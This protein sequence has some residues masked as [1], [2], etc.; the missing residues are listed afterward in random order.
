MLV[1]YTGVL[2]A[3]ISIFKYSKYTREAR[4]VKCFPL[5]LPKAKNLFNSAHIRK[6]CLQTLW[7]DFLGFDF[8]GF[9]LR[10]TCFYCLFGYWFDF[11]ML[12]RKKNS[13]ILLSLIA[14]AF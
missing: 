7:I 5:L 12:F 1:K 3:T 4:G 11:K 2:R 10:R 14:T 9:V 13:H 6:A 8:L